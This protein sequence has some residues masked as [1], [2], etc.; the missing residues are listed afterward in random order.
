MSTG[1]SVD[2]A[3]DRV[4]LPPRHG[5]PGPGGKRFF[6]V[7]SRIPNIGSWGTDSE[8]VERDIPCD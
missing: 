1:R 4:D 8:G 5:S 2:V 3:V 7:R 6:L